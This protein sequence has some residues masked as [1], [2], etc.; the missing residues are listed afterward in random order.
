MARWT[1]ATIERK[2]GGRWQRVTVQPRRALYLNMVHGHWRDAWLSPDGTT[3]LAQ[4]SGECE[5]PTAFFVPAAG[6]HLRPVT[7]ERDWRNSPESVGGG[8]ARDGRA[9]VALLGGACGVGHPEPGE[10]LID[11]KTGA[12]EHVGPLREP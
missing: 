6:G 2:A 7:G 5:V 1:R 4:W 8:W 10:Y 11:P 9:R 3:L 12:L